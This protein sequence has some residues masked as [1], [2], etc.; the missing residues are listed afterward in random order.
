MATVG[1]IGDLTYDVEQMM[2]ERAKTNSATIEK[3]SVECDIVT[4]DSVNWSSLNR[5]NWI[6]C[7]NKEE[8]TW[9]HFPIAESENRDNN[10]KRVKDG[11]RYFTSKGWVTYMLQ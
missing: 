4:V 10:F 6:T 7:I 3:I 11:I 1:L 2:K 9:Y 5:D 8:K